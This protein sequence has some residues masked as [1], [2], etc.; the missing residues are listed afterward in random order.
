MTD[1]ATDQEVVPGRESFAD[2]VNT[3]GGHIY[4]PAV[5]TGRK[6]FS[7]MPMRE[8]DRNEKKTKRIGAELPLHVHWRG[9]PG[10]PAQTRGTT[11]SGNGG[12]AVAQPLIPKIQLIVQLFHMIHRLFESNNNESKRVAMVF[13]EPT[14]KKLTQLITFFL[15]VPHQEQIS[16]AIDIGFGQG[17]LIAAELGAGRYDVAAPARF[18]CPVQIRHHE[19]K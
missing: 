18:V 3:C 10:W 8:G 13:T 2:Q 6:Q 11:D 1:T 9:S 5:T 12:N 4:R 7:Q 19:H 14:R 17:D 16:L 15:I